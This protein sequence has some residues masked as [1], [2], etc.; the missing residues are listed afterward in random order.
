MKFKH[1]LKWL[2]EG[3]I[4]AVGRD[5]PSDELV[6]QLTSEGGKVSFYRESVIESI[7]A[8]FPCYDADSEDSDCDGSSEY[9]SVW[10]RGPRVTSNDVNSKLIPY[11]SE[12]P[13]GCPNYDVVSQLVQKSLSSNSVYSLTE[14]E[15]VHPSPRTHS[16]GNAHPVQLTP[17]TQNCACCSEC[18]ITVTLGTPEYPLNG[19]FAISGACKDC[20]FHVVKRQMMT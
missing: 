10:L 7:S 13:Q 4:S 14:T 12:P 6:Y 17:I 19:M 18:G 11:V 20:L 16:Y 2:P 1:D 15:N 9:Q 3:V 8:L 5:V